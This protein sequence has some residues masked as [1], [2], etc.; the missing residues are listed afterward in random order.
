MPDIYTAARNWICGKKSE[1]CRV[2]KEFFFWQGDSGC[3]MS[4]VTR[5]LSGSKIFIEPDVAI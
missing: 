2:L 4:P 1:H 3:K 5:E